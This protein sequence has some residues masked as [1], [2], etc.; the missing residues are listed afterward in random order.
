MAARAQ[1]EFPTSNEKVCG[2]IDRARDALR[3]LTGPIRLVE[4]P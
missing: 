4:V 3:R 1:A 2:D